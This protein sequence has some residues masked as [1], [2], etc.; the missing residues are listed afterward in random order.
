ML[1][2]TTPTPPFW[3]KHPGAPGC[4]QGLWPPWYVTGWT[5]KTIITWSPHGSVMHRTLQTRGSSPSQSLC[6]AHPPW[7]TPRHSLLT[8]AASRSLRGEFPHSSPNCLPHPSHPSCP[9]CISGLG[10]GNMWGLGP[11]GHTLISTDVQAEGLC[12]SERLLMAGLR[13]PMS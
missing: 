9:K 2:E 3:C 13:D 8:G 5:L 10:H 1:S 7:L 6:R 4:Q 12:T 11:C